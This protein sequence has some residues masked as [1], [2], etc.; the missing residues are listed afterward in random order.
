M[1]FSVNRRVEFRDTDAAGIVHFSAF[2][3]M[4]EFAEHELLRSL[5]ISILPSTA[6]V[7]PGVDASLTWPRV[8]AHC[9]YVAAAR[10]EDLLRISVQVVK[11]GSSS[12]QYRF[13]FSRESEKI[14]VGTMTAVCCR[15]K[16]DVATGATHLEKAVIPDAIRALLQKYAVDE[17]S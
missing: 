16:Q 5:G 7:S 14:A 17:E 15:L 12:V 11:I 9:D 2:F 8:A 10:F 3:P 1:D 6:A 13:V 4:M